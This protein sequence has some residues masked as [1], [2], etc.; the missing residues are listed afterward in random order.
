MCG[1]FIQSSRSASYAR[2]FGVATC[3]SGLD[4]QAARFNI[5]PTQPVLLVREPLA[6]QRELVLVRWGLVP[7]WSAGPD[8]RYSMI[9][10]RAESVHQKPAYREPF[11]RRRGLIPADGFY[12]WKARGK[13][14]QPYC[15]RRMDESPM[16]FAC[17]WDR[18]TGP[19][20]NTLDSCSIIVT[21]S[22]GNLTAIHDRMPVILPDEAWSGWL[23]PEL[24]GV[25]AVRALMANQDQSELSIYPVSRRVNSP[26]NDDAELLA[27]C[28]EPD[29]A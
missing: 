14:K 6:G 5:A 25:E 26:A 10:A 16:A 12:E 11:R 7:A 13:L 18:W 21:Q 1:R 27:A 19:D 20:G 2:I 29:G 8:S 3:Q 4:E 24:R 17:L 9:N 22:L 28:I 15:I 23:D